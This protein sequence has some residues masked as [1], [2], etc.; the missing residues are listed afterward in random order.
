M[1]AR[2]L[3]VLA[4]PIVFCSP[5]LTFSQRVTVQQPVFRNF[6]VGTT[7][8]VPDRGRA[9]LGRVA[10]AGASRK[11]FGPF[12][13]GSS[14]GFSHSHSGMSVGVTIH[15]FEEMD[16]RLLSQSPYRRHASGNIRLGRNAEYAYQSLMHRQTMAEMPSRLRS[17]LGAGISSGGHQRSGTALRMSR[18]AI[19][20]EKPVPNRADYYYSRGLK[21]ERRGADS[22]ARIYYRLAAKRGSASA[23]AKLAAKNVAATTA[24]RN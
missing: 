21:A 10:R 12:H 22:I 15:D 2:I 11:S 6:S 17:R 14:L 3:A 1:P 5:R 24:G 9:F 19:R 18:A 16:R 13:P 23:R 20:P 7:V 4:V 8:S